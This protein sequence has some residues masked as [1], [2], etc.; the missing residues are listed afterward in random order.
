[1]SFVCLAQTY[2]LKK[3]E[4]TKIGCHLGDTAMT[5]V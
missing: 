2:S 4:L 3:L 5:A 1:M